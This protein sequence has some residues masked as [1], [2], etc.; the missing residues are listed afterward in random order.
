MGL[1]EPLSVSFPCEGKEP[2]Y[3]ADFGKGIEKNEWLIKNKQSIILN[4]N[5]I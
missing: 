2:S 4:K 3:K 1:E 5:L